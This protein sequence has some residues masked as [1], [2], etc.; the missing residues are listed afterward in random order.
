[1][2]R[3]CSAS[4]KGRQRRFGTEAEEVSDESK[5]LESVLDGTETMETIDGLFIIKEMKGPLPSSLIDEAGSWWP[6]INRWLA[7]VIGLEKHHGSR[8]S[9]LVAEIISA[10][11]STKADE[12]AKMTSVDSESPQ[13]GAAQEGTSRPSRTNPP[14]VEDSGK[15]SQARRP[16]MDRDS[17]DGSDDEHM[18][19]DEP[20]RNI[21]AGNIRFF[22]EN[23]VV[24]EDLDDSDEDLIEEMEM[25]EAEEMVGFADQV[26]GNAAFGAG[27]HAPTANEEDSADEPSS[28]GSD[29]EA[30][31]TDASYVFASV[32]QSPIVS[33]QPSLL[34]VEKIG[35]GRQG[36]V[37]E[38]DSASAV[39]A[40][41]SHLGLIHRKS[42]IHWREMNGVTFFTYL[43]SLFSHSPTLR[44]SNLQL[45]SLA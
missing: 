28:S 7:A 2:L 42:K 11:A 35:P 36:S 14:P 38:A 6:L 25:D 22:G 18:E 37:F 19:V 33:Y 20:V 10:P 17:S 5:A 1:M 8:G 43:T 39:M 21:R 26:L 45:D 32:A 44:H 13:V 24:D 16:S 40:D 27:R 9:S 15:T 12:D 29:G 30:D 41:M 4:V 34:A 31:T 3:A 23:H